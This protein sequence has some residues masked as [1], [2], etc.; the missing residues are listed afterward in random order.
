M[1]CL[2][3]QRPFEQPSFVCPQYVVTYRVGGSALLDP[4][5][6]RRDGNNASLPRGGGETLEVVFEYGTTLHVRYPA[7]IVAPGASSLRRASPARNN[8]DNRLVPVVMQQPVLYSASAILDN[9]AN[10]EPAGR[11]LAYAL[12]MDNVGNDRTKTTTM[13]WSSSS[14]FWVADNQMS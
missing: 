3:P 9:V 10:N 2:S 4:P 6:R 13:T 14:W 7:T 12:R 5:P 11:Q 8:N 1:T